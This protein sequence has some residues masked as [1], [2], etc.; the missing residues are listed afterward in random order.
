MSEALGLT[1]IRPEGTD[2]TCASGSGSMIDYALVTTRFP[3]V[4]MHVEAVKTVPWGPHYGLR[5]K[6]RTDTASIM[7]SEV[8]RAPERS[9][10]VAQ[11]HNKSPG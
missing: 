3:V 10:A 5:A 7:I 1:L 11:L 6:F 2:I 8:V 9:Q 4:V